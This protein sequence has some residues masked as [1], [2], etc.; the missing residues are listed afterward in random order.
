MSQDV[1]GEE[2]GSGGA[3]PGVDAE[4]PTRSDLQDRLDQQAA[5]LERQSQLVQQLVDQLEAAE[6]ERDDLREQLQEVRADVDDIDQRTDLLRLVEESDDL[7]P[8]QRSAILVEAARK[9]AARRGRRDNDEP[10]RYALTRDEG[11]AALHL[12]EDADRTIVYKDM[13]RAER[14]VGNTDLVAYQ[15][16]ELVVD[17]TAGE[18]PSSIGGHQIGENHEEG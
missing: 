5:R 3:N 16:G 10:P 11:E 12:P 1:T 14:L 13:D 8:E 2:T 15:D 9:K 4:K 6:E 7:A 18:L 17:L